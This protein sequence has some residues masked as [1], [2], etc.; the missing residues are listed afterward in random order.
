MSP[1]AVW[2]KGWTGRWPSPSTTGIV[3]TEPGV[4]S[5]P[6]R[7]L[8]HW[9]FTVSPAPPGAAVRKSSGLSTRSMFMVP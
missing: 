2:V 1:A 9:T 7:V 5:E 3:S 6:S 8:M 4:S